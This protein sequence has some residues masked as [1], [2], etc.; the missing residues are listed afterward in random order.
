MTLIEGTRID[1]HAALVE[2]FRLRGDLT[3]AFIIRAVAH[4]KIDFFGSVLGRFPARSGASRHD[5]AP[6][7]RARRRRRGA[8]AVG[9]PAGRI[10]QGDLTAL[11]VWREVANGKRLAGAQ[12]VTW[13][14]LRDLG[15]AAT[16]PS[17]PA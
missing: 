14:M 5:H 8:V 6:G 12:E 1:E 9:G 7:G 2:H 10:A 11:K 15:E 16:T 17:S 13:L 4:G 3:P